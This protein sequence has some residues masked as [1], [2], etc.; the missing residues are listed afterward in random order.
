MHETVK[1]TEQ[2]SI[3][4]NQKGIVFVSVYLNVISYR[5]YVLQLLVVPIALI[6]IYLGFAC[7]FVT[8]YV[9]IEHQLYFL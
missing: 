5:T 8:G 3:S 7:T 4:D 1:L 9:S 6:S 2:R